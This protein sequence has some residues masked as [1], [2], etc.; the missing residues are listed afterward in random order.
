MVSP[1]PGRQPRL[2][3]GRATRADRIGRARTVS[4]RSRLVAVA[5]LIAAVAATVNAAPARAKFD[6]AP[7]SFD[8]GS[9]GVCNDHVDPITLVF[10][11][12][13]ATRENTRAVVQNEM[14]WNGDTSAAGQWALSSGYCNT[15]DGQSTN[16]CGTCNRD[17]LRYNQTHEKDLKNRYETVGT[18]HRE[19][20]AT[21]W[22]AMAST[23]FVT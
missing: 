7:Y 4:N 14:G 12:F 23:S 5:L 18:P 11:G 3:G 20:W 9:G 8:S 22:S 21:P 10:Y 16:G 17:H 15:M 1:S 13:T 2:T 6:S 19:I